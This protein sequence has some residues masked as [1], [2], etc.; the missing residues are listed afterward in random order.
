MKSKKRR[1]AELF[2]G[3]IALVDEDGQILARA[4]KGL[5]GTFKY[6]DIEFIDADS[7]MLYMEK[8]KGEI[9]EQ[10]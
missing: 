7:A 3:H 9:G 4:I 5:D 2:N 6:K 1:W 10:K 8:E